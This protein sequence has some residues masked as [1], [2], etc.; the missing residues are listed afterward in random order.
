MG[1]HVAAHPATP[2]RGRGLLLACPVLVAADSNILPR[3]H[4]LAVLHHLRYRGGARISTWRLLQRLAPPPPSL[5]SSFSP[6]Q[7]RKISTTGPDSGPSPA[8]YS[9][10]PAGMHGPT[11]LIYWGQLDTFL[12]T[13]RDRGES[14]V[15]AGADELLVLLDVRALDRL[16]LAVALG[17]RH[18]Q[19][20]LFGSDCSNSPRYEVCRQCGHIAGEVRQSE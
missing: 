3:V 6:T 17:I 14:G 16:V 8:V 15:H 10:V 2:T 19:S 7:V 12:A 18:V 13:G 11:V 9:R 4:A 1:A 20:L 5:A